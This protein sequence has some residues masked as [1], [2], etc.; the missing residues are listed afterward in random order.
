MHP[1][2]PDL[3]LT[4]R[5]YLLTR[6]PHQMAALEALL[7][8]AGAQT[9]CF[10]TL[11]IQPLALSPVAVAH[12]ND[13][14]SKAPSNASLPVWWLF[15]SANGVDALWSQLS[16]TQQAQLQQTSR[17][18]RIACVGTQTAARLMQYGVT[19]DHVPEV[20]HGEALARHL[21]HLFREQSPQNLTVWQARAGRTRL[22]DI[23]RQA[24]HQV[25]TFAVYQ[26][27][28]PVTCHAE[29]LATLLQNHQPD[30]VIFT[31]PS[32]VRHF[33]ECLPPCHGKVNTL[34]YHSI[35]PVTS[36]A[37]ERYLGPVACEAN[38][39]TLA[40]LVERL[41]TDEAQYQV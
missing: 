20:H 40:G 35:G 18:V 36:A 7:H 3:P 12:I 22:Q 41:C 24:G 39:H 25:T 16:A 15:T 6:A 37:I 8:R 2:P 30:G 26:T 29:G 9:L 27:V 34:K 17:R 21:Q 10:P 5:T 31:S 38:P 1:V 4:G 11:E 14:L 23:L 28:K 32:S 19:T 33:C 13:C